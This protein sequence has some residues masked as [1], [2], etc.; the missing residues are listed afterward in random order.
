MQGI[1]RRQYQQDTMDYMSVPGGVFAVL[2]DGMGGL[3]DG[4]KVS[5]MIVRTM[6]SDAAN[7]SQT[8]SG[9]NLMQL[10]A[11]TNAEVNQM[12]SPDQAWYLRE[13]YLRMERV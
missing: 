9:N 2:A 10:L 5:Q 4:D 3:S 1:G 12:I 6:M 7:H 11:H 8:E 13:K